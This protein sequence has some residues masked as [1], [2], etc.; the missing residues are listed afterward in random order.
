[1]YVHVRLGQK[2]GHVSACGRHRENVNGPLLA[3]Y[4]FEEVSQ[5]NV[6][7]VVAHTDKTFLSLIARPE[8]SISI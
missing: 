1:V 7:V 5:G 8:F 3:R 2:P 6:A 4:S